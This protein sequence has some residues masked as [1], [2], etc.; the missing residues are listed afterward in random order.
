[1]ETL[2]KEATP[3]YAP[4]YTLTDSYVLSSTPYLRL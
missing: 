4:Y 3:N 2:P 1:V